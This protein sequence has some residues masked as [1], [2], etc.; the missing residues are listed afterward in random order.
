MTEHKYAV[1]RGD[2]QNS[3]AVHVHKL[4][5]GIDWESARVH[6]DARGYWQRRTLESIQIRRE[7]TMNLDCMWPPH[8][9]CL[10]PTAGCNMN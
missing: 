2:E 7:R 8:L 9:P 1:H 5:H 4:Q 6:V 10:E 3:I